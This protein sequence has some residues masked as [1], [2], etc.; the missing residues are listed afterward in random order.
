MVIAAEV[1]D[2]IPSAVIERIYASAKNAKSRRLH[3]VPN[4]RHLSLFPRDQDFLSVRNMIIE[5]CRNGRDNKAVL[6]PS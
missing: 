5:I 4:S 3:I 2:V 1:D 6:A